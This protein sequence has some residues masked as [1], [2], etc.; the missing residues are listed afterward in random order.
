M[1]KPLAEAKSELS[2]AAAYL[3]WYAEEANRIYGETISAPSTDRRMLVIK[4]PVGVVG[5]ITPW[6]F[7]AS[8][9]GAQDLAGAGRRLH[10]RLQA[11]RADA[12][13]RWCHVMPW[14]IAPAFPRA[15]STWSC[16]ATATR[17]AANSAPTPGSARSASPAR[18]RSAGSSCAQCSDQIKQL[19]LELG[20]NAP[21][22]VF[23]DADVDAAVEAR[24]RQVPQRRPDLHLRKPPLRPVAA[25]TT[26]SPTIA[27]GSASSQVGDGF[28]A[29]CDRPADRQAGAQQD[30][31]RISTMPSQKAATILCGGQPHR[32]GGTSS[33]RRSS[34]MSTASM[35]I[36]QEETF[37]PVAPII[38]FE[39]ADQVV[40][41]ANDTIYGLAAY[42]YATEPEA[43]LACGRSAWNTA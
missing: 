12:A 4:Q 26:N 21:F 37:G 35:P 36:A 2:H 1:G 16:V 20:G 9:V 39:D 5:T 6:N 41:A 42:F 13:R 28:E 11:C 32:Q 14:P 38:R 25:F 15:W 33:S 24:S 18:P 34:P 17:S 3:Q 43:C 8:M 19:S 30:R 27:D 31:N 29:V 22:I 7:P 40:H 23:D 10:G